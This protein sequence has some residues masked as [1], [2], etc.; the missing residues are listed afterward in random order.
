M[1]GLDSNL[2]F[3]LCPKARREAFTLIELLVVIAIIAIL[4]SMLLPVLHQAQLRGQTADCISNQS[5]LARAWVMYSAD[6]N[7]ACVG[8]WWQHEQTWKAHPRENWVA[9]WIGVA[10]TGGDGTSGNVGGPDN[11]N[12]ALLVNPQY[13]ALGD[14]TKIPTLY[15]CPASQV[16]GSVVNGGQR[17]FLLCR[18]VSM[19]CWMGWNTPIQGALDGSTGPY[20]SDAANYKWFKKVTDITAGIGPSDAFVFMEERA[21][22]IDDGWFAVD[23]PRSLLNLVNWPTDYHNEAATVGF[24]DGHV[25]VHRWANA[26]FSSG[27][28]GANFL[29]P[30]NSSPGGKWGGATAAPLYPGGLP[31][32]MQHATCVHQ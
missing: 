30:Q 8:N 1:P 10:D 14:Y 15:L 21:E 29:T 4:A 27:P 17:S 12:T 3:P 5:Q 16:R 25:D 20:F 28:P 23:G 31:W 7:D 19:N 22:S 24:A 26:K 32:M 18:T 13:S 11:T 6:N 2:N 9:G